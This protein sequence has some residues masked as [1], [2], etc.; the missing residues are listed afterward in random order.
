VLHQLAILKGD[1]AAIAKLTMPDLM[2]LLVA[3]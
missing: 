2:K 1:R 3:A